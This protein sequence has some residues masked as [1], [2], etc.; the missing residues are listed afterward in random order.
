MESIKSYP[1]SPRALADSWVLRTG[2]GG[3]S[4]SDRRRLNSPRFV[5]DRANGLSD[6][7]E[8]HF[9]RVRHH[10]GDTPE[11]RSLLDPLEAARD[12]ETRMG[13]ATGLRSENGYFGPYPLADRWVLCSGPGGGPLD[14]PLR[15]IARAQALSEL[16]DEHYRRA[17]HYLGD[18]PE[19][20]S[21]AALLQAARDHVIR[22]TRA[23]D[24]SFGGHG[25]G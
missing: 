14:D 20:R 7:L 5:I 19:V 18:T 12:H 17:E 25:A 21:L 10:I 16:L 8:A 4:G 13:R 3:G 24:T 23:A 9:R 6:L 1:Q 15:C 2:L 22:M 11:L